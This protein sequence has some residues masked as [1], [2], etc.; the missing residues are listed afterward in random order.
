MNE[1]IVIDGENLGNELRIL[2]LSS[3]PISVSSIYSLWHIPLHLILVSRLSLPLISFYSLLSIALFQIWYTIHNSIP[4]H[5]S[6]GY[7]ILLSRVHLVTVAT[8]TQPSM[9]TN[10]LLPM[11]FHRIY[12][13]LHSFQNPR[14]PMS[15][16]LNK[17]ITSFFFKLH[18]LDESEPN[19]DLTFSLLKVNLHLGGSGHLPTQL[20]ELRIFLTNSFPWWYLHLWWSGIIMCWWPH[21]IQA[22]LLSKGCDHPSARSSKLERTYLLLFFWSSSKLWEDD[23]LGWNPIQGPFKLL[24]A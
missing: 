24:T 7:T 8:P 9:S 2:N 21:L 23:D 6:L 11:T 10:K 17:F 12:P 19:F 14:M 4:L 5:N 22:N 3:A 13:H 18:P 20:S 16:Q 1:K 15:N